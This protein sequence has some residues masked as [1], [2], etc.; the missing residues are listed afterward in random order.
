MRVVILFFL[1]ICFTKVSF[2]QTIQKGF[3][4]LKAKNYNTAEKVFRATQKKYPSASSFGLAKLYLTND[5]RNSDSA[6]RFILI[7]EQKWSSLD[8]KTR[9]KLCQFNFDSVAIQNLKLDVSDINYLRSEKNNTAFDFQKFIDNHNWSPKCVLAAIKRDSLLF[10][11]AKNCG[12]WICIF[13]FINS[14]PNSHLKDFAQGLMEDLQYAESTKSAS[15]SDYEKFLNTFPNNKHFRDAENEIYFRS[16]PTESLDELKQFVKTYPSNSNIEKAWRKLYSTYNLEYSLIRL[17]SFPIEFPDFPYMNIL[18]EDIVLYNTIFFPFSQNG[19]FGYMNQ[20]GAIL[21][22][23]IYDE[24]SEF[25]EGLAVVL[26]SGKSGLI[27]KRNQLISEFRYDEITDFSG[28]RAIVKISDFIGVIDRGGNTI[29]PIEYSDIFLIKDKL[30]CANNDDLFSLYDEN[31]KIK[32]SQQFQEINLQL[33][34]DFIVRINDSIGVIDSNFKLKINPIY[35]S[36]KFIHDTVYSYQINGKIGLISKNGKIIT[37]ALFD[38]ISTYNTEAKNIIAR[39]TNTI[40]YLNLDGSKFLP[41]LYDYFPKAFDIARF[42]SDKAVFLKKGKFGIMDVK[43]KVLIKAI[44]ND[45]RFFGKNISVM[46]ANKFGLIDLKGNTLLPFD[47]DEIEKF[48]QLG[49][50]VEKNGLLGFIN[51]DLKTILPLNFKVIKQFSPL[52]LLV[53]DGIKFGLY[54]ITGS[55]VIPLLYD[56]IQIFNDDCI[57]LINESEISYFFINSGKY[58]KRE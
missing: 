6:Y 29:L 38:D 40:C 21:I 41:E 50:L 16:T 46:K 27:N 35:E 37:R 19:R 22:P 20:N 2:S 11:D 26:L 53:S 25:Q 54:S 48:N 13:D 9:E 36:I 34:G 52:Y 51:K 23:A 3:E 12:S 33:N 32:S 24:V 43:G 10:I 4:A 42:N 14:H 57:S 47:F 44:Y 39:L 8:Q 5:Y 31:G 17:K 56:R 45:L 49:F 28:N 1:C 15:V 7:A 58:L 18:D 55:L 30:F